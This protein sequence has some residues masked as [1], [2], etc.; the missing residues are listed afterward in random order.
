MLVRFPDSCAHQSFGILKKKMSDIL[1]LLW[2]QRIDG[3]FVRSNALELNAARIQSVV[4][5]A[6]GAVTG[7]V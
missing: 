3:R 7:A 5:G 1:I 2:R 4:V 6:S